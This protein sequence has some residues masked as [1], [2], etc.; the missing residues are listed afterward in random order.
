MKHGGSESLAGYIGK[1]LSRGIC[2]DGA[3]ND[4]ISNDMTVKFFLLG[5]S[6]K[7]KGAFCSN[8]F[9]KGN[10]ITLMTHAT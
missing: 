7:G 1:D 3:E 10:M 9:I 6:S 5:K 8:C 2:E 4:A